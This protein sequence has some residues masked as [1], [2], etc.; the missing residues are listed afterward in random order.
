MSF[1]GKG[2]EPRFGEE[3]LW[4]ALEQI[5]ESGVIGRKKI[6]QKLDI[7]EGSTRTV[8]KILKEKGL[9][10][11]TPQGHSLTETGEKELSKRQSKMVPLEAE[12]LTVGDFDIAI[13]VRGG[14]SKIK[15]GIKQRDEAI[16]AGAKGATVLEYISG[17]LQTPGVK[18]GINKKI[19]E[20]LT[21]SFD[22]K[23][24]DAIVIGTGDNKKEAGRGA[25]AAAE[26]LK[27]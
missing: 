7:G 18:M 23:E 2:P 11:S 26:S 21:E 25:L 24:G 13:L 16:K 4:E 14:T 19:T 1:S 9:I 12:D 5:G 6:S 27:E 17:E 15:Q 10:K 22:L 20:K 3:H 8:L